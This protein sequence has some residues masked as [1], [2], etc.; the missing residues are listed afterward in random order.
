MVRPCARFLTVCAVLAVAGAGA[1]LAQRP[2]TDPVSTRHPAIDYLNKSVTDPV[3]ALNQRI[4]NGDVQLTFEAGERGYLKSVLQALKIPVESQML[5]YSETSLQ[6]E[7]ITQKTPRAL[8]F[9]DTVSVGWVRSADTLELASWDPQQG[10]QF[11]QV[12]QK[13]AQRPHFNRSQRC[14]ECHEGN[15]TMGISGMLTMS[16][17]PLSD[18]QND[19]AQGWAVDQRTPFEDRWGGWFVTGAAVPP[20]HLGNVPVYHVKKSGVR[21]AVTPKLT[22]VAGTIDAAA[23]PT[24]TSDVVALMVFNHQTFMTNLMT[25]LNWATRVQD[26]DRLHPAAPVKQASMQATD[27]PVAN[28]VAELVDHLLF[29][30]EV[31]LPGKVQGNSGF[32]EVFAA[33]G[34]KDAKGRSLRELDLS[35]RLMKYP[36]SYLIYAPAFDAL[37]ARAK[38]MV[39]DRLWTVLSGKDADPAYRKLTAEDRQA[40]IEI[41]RDTKSD[42]PAAF[43]RG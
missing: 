2:P 24:A 3:A 15:L 30:D 38:A 32:A 28:I 10:L 7:H 16:M 21:A 40:V 13:P 36:C 26:W 12:D 17:L 43:T 27:D 31:P 19:Y 41:L 4:I 22:S 20:R 29:V 9:N 33:Q 39:Y 42:L 8:Y 1:L 37:P 23:Y 14:L 25:R 34:P 35:R 18:N 11:Y 6:S 5:V